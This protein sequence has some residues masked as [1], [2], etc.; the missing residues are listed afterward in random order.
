LI[1]YK[2]SG[3]ITNQA[4]LRKFF[5]S[6]SDGV[7]FLKADSRNQRSLNQNNYFHGPVLEL[8]LDGLR[9]MGY[10]EV[11]D[12][13]DAK[14]V[15]KSLFL[16]KKITNGVEEIEVIRDTSTL[17]NTRNDHPFIKRT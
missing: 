5:A 6:L 16:R 3:Q 9:D 14:T 8:I 7:Y 11:K 12:K 10:S 4:A 2:Q 17:T 1:I 15:L 13:T